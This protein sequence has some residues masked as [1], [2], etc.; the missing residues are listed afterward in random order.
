MWPWLAWP[1][2]DVWGSPRI[3][4]RPHS[5]KLHCPAHIPGM[6][7]PPTSPHPC[8]GQPPGLTCLSGRDVPPQPSRPSALPLPLPTFPCSF[9][10]HICRCHPE[11]R[12]PYPVIH[13]RVNP[14]FLLALPRP[15]PSPASPSSLLPICP[16]D[17]IVVESAALS[18][19]RASI[20][21]LV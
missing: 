4:T 18:R 20:V 15:S 6:C 17:Y 14:L 7:A 5:P 8:P 21:A 3:I 12:S 19:G 1:G 9:F 11:G 13:D 10:P 16:D 2:R